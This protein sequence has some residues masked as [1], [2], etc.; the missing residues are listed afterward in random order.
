MK[1]CTLLI[2]LLVATSLQSDAQQEATKID[3]TMWGL[4]HNDQKTTYLV[5]YGDAVGLLGFAGAVGGKSPEEV[6]KIIYAMWP[7][8][9]DLGK[10]GDELDKLCPTAPFK[11]M[12][13]SLVIS[14][15]A[16]KAQR[17]K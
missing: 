17:K 7:Q 4:W 16:V 12:R 13:V 9:Y 10:L 15:L 3:C 11:K 5:G 6:Q 14:G 1:V 2:L 8:G